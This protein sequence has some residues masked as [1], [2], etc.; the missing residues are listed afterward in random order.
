[1]LRSILNNIIKVVEMNPQELKSYIEQYQARKNG[2]EKALAGLTESFII[3]TIQKGLIEN[4][5]DISFVNNEGK[6]I[7]GDDAIDG[8]SGTSFDKAVKQFEKDFTNKKFEKEDLG[9]QLEIKK[10][11]QVLMEQMA[12]NGADP[13]DLASY[14]KAMKAADNQNSY[15]IQISFDDESF[16][17]DNNGNR[18]TMNAVTTS[19][20][21]KLKENGFEGDGLYWDNFD[22]VEKLAEQDGLVETQVNISNHYLDS[23]T[24]KVTIDDIEYQFDAPKSKLGYEFSQQINEDKTLIQGIVEETL[25]E[26]YEGKNASLGAVIEKSDIDLNW[27]QDDCSE[28]NAS[29]IES[30]VDK[31]K[32]GKFK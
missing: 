24:T 29:V 14:Q 31:G 20:E 13:E 15:T 10:T 19:L 28:H 27:S 6:L 11:S 30:N 4:G 12:S 18:E 26:V 3:E 25:R 2:D 22:G 8:K 21:R 7:S 32:A 23:A 17:N 16:M 1:M 5:Y 9:F